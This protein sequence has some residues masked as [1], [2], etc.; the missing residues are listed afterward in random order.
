[1]AGLNV[2][3]DPS[4]KRDLE[5]LQEDTGWSANRVIGRAIKDMLVLHFIH[6]KQAADAGGA[7]GKLLIRVVHEFG[8]GLLVNRTLGYGEDERT[9]DPLLSATARDTGEKSLFYEDDTGR[10]LVQR[11]RDGVVQHFICKDGEL[12]LLDA[13]LAKGSP[14]LN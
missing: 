3:L 12:Q 4:R 9:G 6:R 8:A 1:M 13:Y 14:I 5:L 10:L 7:H 11:T 2:R